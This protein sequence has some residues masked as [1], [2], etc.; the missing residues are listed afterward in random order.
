METM[1]REATPHNIFFNEDNIPFCRSAETYVELRLYQLCSVN[2][3]K[4]QIYYEW[5]TNK[6]KFTKQTQTII[7]DFQYYSLHDQSHSRSI[8]ESIEMFLGKDRLNKLG[9]GDLWLLLNCAYSH[10]IGMSMR[11]EEIQELWRDNKD[12]QRYI[13]EEVNNMDSNAQEA[14]QYY[15]QLRNIIAA[16]EQMEGI[17][18]S[19]DQ[20]LK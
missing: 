8:I 9:I 11:H 17:E 5:Q 3:R 14:L 19:R 7:Y 4:K 16:T 6:Q 20:I 13:E 12:F 15:W 10:D 2:E 18:K 1:G